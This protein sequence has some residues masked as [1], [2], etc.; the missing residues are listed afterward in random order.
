MSLVRIA[1][2]TRLREGRFLQIGLIMTFWI[3]GEAFARL[4]GVPVPGSVI[5]LFLVLALLAAGWIKPAAMR[6]GAQWFMAEMLL[7]FIPAVLAVLDHRE[8]LGLLGLKVLAVI[9]TGTLVVMG[10]TALAVEL[11]LRLTAVP[12]GPD[13]L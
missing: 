6:R 13:D 4:S 1:S 10:T 7:F 3:T 2:I 8:F 12:G 9:V 11:V 5:G